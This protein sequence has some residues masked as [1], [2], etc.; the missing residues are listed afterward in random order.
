MVPCAVI[1]QN[2]CILSTQRSKTMSLPLKWEFPGGKVDDGETEI[3]ALEREILEEL[4]VAIEV[5]ERMTPTLKED[6]NRIICLIPYICT[7]K[8]QDI[9]LTEHAQY[10]WI[11]LDEIDTLDWAEAD[12]GVIDTYMSH[13]LVV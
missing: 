2:G 13:C 9:V 10:C 7:L 12:W 3:E 6:T 8:S 11:P 1:E 4:S 5:G